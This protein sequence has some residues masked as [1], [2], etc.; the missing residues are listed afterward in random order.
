HELSKQQG[1][2][3]RCE[4]RLDHYRVARGQG[5]RELPGAERE[6]AIEGRDR[7]DDADRLL[8]DL[9]ALGRGEQERMLA[10]GLD[11][12]CVIAIPRSSIGDLS[13]RRGDGLTGGERLELGKRLDL[14]L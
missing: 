14:G 11:H 6:R 1:T 8:A 2:G 5:G 13:T 3:T 4:R 9:R 12:G 7:A 10:L